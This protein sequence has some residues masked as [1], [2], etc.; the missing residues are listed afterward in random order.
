M[1]LPVITNDINV[2]YHLWLFRV[3]SLFTT[4]WCRDKEEGYLNFPFS[5]NDNLFLV[6]SVV[7]HFPQGVAFI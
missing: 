4:I 3:T 1:Y 7:Q 6:M 2:S 5:S